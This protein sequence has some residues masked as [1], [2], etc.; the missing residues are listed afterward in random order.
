MHLTGGFVS[1][2]LTK[3]ITNVGGTFMCSVLRNIGCAL[4]I[5]AL[6]SCASFGGRKILVEFRNAEGIRGGEAVYL[7]GVKVGKVTDEPSVANG[8]ARV[9][10]HIESKHKD[11]IPAGTVF[12]I[13]ADPNDSKVQ[14]L[15]GYALGSVSPPAGG[16]EVLYVGA[17][18]KAELVLM[19]GTEKASKLWEEFTK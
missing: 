10:V 13:M 15:I 9:P 18:N 7:A 3:L 19:L 14:C 2:S 12:L 16:A 1:D 11:G 4:A 6:V 17:S 5:V 8:K